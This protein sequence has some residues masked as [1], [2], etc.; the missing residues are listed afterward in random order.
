MIIQAI[1]NELAAFY[2]FTQAGSLKA[3][4]HVFDGAI[5]LLPETKDLE[6]IEGLLKDF[7]EAV[8]TVVID[9]LD[10]ELA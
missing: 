4:G 2:A 10:L 1:R 8:K 5:E 9:G 3:F 7:V 6:L